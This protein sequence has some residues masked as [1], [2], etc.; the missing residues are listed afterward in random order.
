MIGADIRH[1]VFLANAE[2]G[3]KLIPPAYALAGLY[4]N[5]IPAQFLAL[6]KRLQILYWLRLHWLA[7]LVPWNQ[8]LGSLNV[9]KNRLRLHWLA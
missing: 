4:N 9:Y 5:P 2:H 1:F 8:F 3:K 6:L 7:E